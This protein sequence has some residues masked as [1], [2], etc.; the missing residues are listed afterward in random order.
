MKTFNFAFTVIFLVSLF[1]ACSEPTKEELI[2]KTFN[3]Y[4]HQ[5]FDDPNDLKE[6]L[7]IEIED[8][9]SASKTRTFIVGIFDSSDSIFSRL[10]FLSDSLS[11]IHNSNFEKVKS[12]YRLTNK[13]RGDS[14]LQKM[15]LNLFENINE[16]LSFKTSSDYQDLKITNTSLNGILDSL[17]NDS[18]FIVTYKIKTR[19][20]QNNE[21]KIKDYYAQLSDM[22]TIK[23]FDNNNLD[24]YPILHAEAYKKA[25]LYTKQS[26][27]LLEILFERIKLYQR[28]IEYMT[29]E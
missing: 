21:L 25:D 10:Y 5:N 22:N 11:A 16:E 9:L 12:S 8:T 23:I 3:E 13:Y 1:T 18:T 28:L 15:T 2:E 4:V 29:I 24:S 17:K 19:V 20:S 14:F 26:K 6:I 7:S 27:K